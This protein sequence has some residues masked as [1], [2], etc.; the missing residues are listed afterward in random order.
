MNQQWGMNAQIAEDSCSRM[1][2]STWVGFQ[3]ARE[4]CSGWLTARDTWVEVQSKMVPDKEEQL[5]GEPALGMHLAEEQPHSPSLALVVAVWSVWGTSGGV[6][7]VKE[8]GLRS[9][10]VG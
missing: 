6:V 10:V 4:L 9:E 2:C 3:M 7:E 1:E 5:C 8:E